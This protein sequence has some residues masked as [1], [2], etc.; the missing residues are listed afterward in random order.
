MYG[1]VPIKILLIYDYIYI[2]N[3]IVLVMYNI[4]Y[5]ISNISYDNVLTILS[6]ADGSISNEHFFLCLSEGSV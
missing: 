1:I 5:H 3:I 4:I 6:E 2:Y